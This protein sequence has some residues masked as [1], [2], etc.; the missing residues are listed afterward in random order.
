MALNAIRAKS[1]LASI[2]RVIGRN[3]YRLLSRREIVGAAVCTVW[4]AGCSLLPDPPAPQIYRLRPQADDP[5]SGPSLRGQL[6]IDMPSAPQSL[7]A[8]LR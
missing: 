6:A 3:E 7:D 2:R 1:C 5:P 8:E 4:L